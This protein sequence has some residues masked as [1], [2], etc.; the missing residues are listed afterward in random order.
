M[1]RIPLTRLGPPL[2]F[3]T[4][5]ML[6]WGMKRSPL[7][8][9]AQSIGQ[10]P[11]PTSADWPQ[12]RGGPRQRGV[13]TGCLP[14]KPR[15]AWRYE[16]GAALRSSPVVSAGRVVFGCD[17]GRVIC[18]ALKDGRELWTMRTGG[19]VEAPPT[20]DGGRVFIG[21]HDERLYAL[22]LASGKKIWTVQTEA[23]VT[24]GALVAG[25]PP[26]VIFGSHD[27]YLRALRWADGGE[28][29]RYETGSYLN[30][31]PALAGQTIVIGGCDSALHRV[32]LD[33]KAREPIELESHVASSVALDRGRAF[34]A[35]YGNAVDC[36][37]LGPGRGGKLRWRYAS[38]F[39]FFSSP[40]LAGGLVVVGCRDRRV[41]AIG[42]DDGKGRWRTRLRGKVDASPVIVGEEVIVASTGGE[43]AILRLRDGSKRWSY[44][45]GA[46]VL[47][48]P[49]FARGSI[50]VATESGR[51]EA[52]RER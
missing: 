3:L 27:G 14:A 48:S 19:A 24:G 47:A 43:L 50:L 25:A 26:L 44:D 6:S 52:F 15:S 7:V 20:I 37:E 33:G 51:I 31:S 22:E 8:P 39:P 34:V 29:W 5:A 10:A 2:I 9:R 30:G 12:H 23:K 38:R 32:D 42:E 35:H 46:G 17:D 4:L 41:H 49:A 36:V 40:A 18:L 13:A 1:K 11:K 21:S 28:I 16:A 45:L